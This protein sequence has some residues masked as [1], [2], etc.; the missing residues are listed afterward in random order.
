[1]KGEKR[2]CVNVPQEIV[3][4]ILVKLPVKS[5][6]RFKAVST[7]WERTIESKYF[8]EKHNRYQKSLQVGQVRIVL[9]SEEKRYNGLALKNLLVSA[10]GI[11]HVSP[12][13][14]IRAFNR[15]D[16]YKISEP[17][18]GLIC[19]YTYSRIFNLVNPATTSRRRIPDPTPPYSFNGGDMVLTLL[20]IGRENSVSLRYKLVW[21]FEC[22]IKRVN[23]STRC[24]VFALDSNT[25]RYV[26]PPHCRVHYRHSLIHLD[27]VMYCFA[28]MEEPRLFE[29][30]PK[31]LAFDL[32][33]ETFQINSIPPDIGCRYCHELSMCVL[34]HRICIFKR[35]V[36]DKDCF[37]KIWG[38]DIDKR[39][40]E[41]MY[42]IDLSCFP[43][44]FNVGKGKRI[45]PIATINDYVIISNFD[46]TIWVLYSSKSCILYNTSFA[47]HLVMSY[48]ETLVSTYQ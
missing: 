5:L 23:K 16:G 19:L 2:R 4:E 26:D 31:L 39:S 10:S 24:M 12:C 25:W 36:D 46:R 15:F 8:I 3:Q 37:L 17:C 47:G 7:E 33:T 43:P 6:A 40:W 13:L 18:D 21:F 11:V 45:I 20:G 48:F 32:H 30:D 27:G 35:F 22:D 29:E 28:Y 42:S 9:F 1:M 38:L 14:P 34:N 44:E 41:T